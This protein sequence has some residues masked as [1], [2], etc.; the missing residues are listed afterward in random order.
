VVKSITLKKFE[1]S[2]LKEKKNK[3]YVKKVKSKD[4]TKEVEPVLVEQNT[5][6]KSETSKVLLDKLADDKPQNTINELERFLPENVSSVFKTFIIQQ[7]GT[8]RD[9]LETLNYVVNTFGDDGLNVL[10]KFKAKFDEEVTKGNHYDSIEKKWN[11][12]NYTNEEVLALINP[13]EVKPKDVE[14]LN[15][16]TVVLNHQAITRKIEDIDKNGNYMPGLS[17]ELK[18]MF[19]IDKEVKEKLFNKKDETPVETKDE[20]P[21]ETKDETL[22]E[23]KDEILAV[24]QPLKTE[25]DSTFMFKLVT[26]I[27]GL[28]IIFGFIKLDMKVNSMS[29]E[30][31][32]F[33]ER[34][35]LKIKKSEDKT[36][37]IIQSEEIKL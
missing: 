2:E 26:F 18:L 6:T 4:G 32:K 34:K 35:E 22:V 5:P 16:V 24:Y 28:I 31:R 21:V 3:K 14:P 37:K 9:Y 8:K 29:D 36:P 30:I 23:T 7:I 25:D 19:E 12:V 15:D 33:N 10:K 27:F 1:Q 17:E 20:T 13:K 11:K